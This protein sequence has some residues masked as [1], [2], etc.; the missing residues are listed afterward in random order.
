MPRALAVI[1][2]VSALSLLVG[3]VVALRGGGSTWSR[4]ADSY[5]RSAIGH[6][7]LANL[8]DELGIPV[9]RA[10]T[11]PREL[12]PR[13][14]VAVLCEPRPDADPDSIRALGRWE[15]YSSLAYRLLLVL[16]RWEAGA[17]H[18]EKV[19]WIGGRAELPTSTVDAVAGMLELPGRVVRPS[20]PLT[21]WDLPEDLPLPTLA[22]P[23]LL[24]A[25]DAGNGRL[26]P[27]WS[28]DQG[29]LLARWE[30]Q[31]TE[32]TVLVLSDPDL[33]NNLG[34]GR[35]ANAQ[36]A[37]AALALAGAPP[38]PVLIDETLHGH[39]LPRSPGAALLRP[40]LLWLLLHLG[41]L[42]LALLWWANQ[43]FG[44]PAPAT[45]AGRD[46]KAF[47]VASTASLLLVGGHRGHLLRRYLDHSIRGA[48]RARH[49]PATGPLRGVARRVD[50]LPG[51][52]RGPSAGAITLCD[53]MLARADRPLAAGGLLAAAR[54]IHA[55]TREM[56]HGTR[57]PARDHRP[58][59]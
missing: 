47:L 24:Q 49:V 53:R 19:H 39:A 18:P 36:L 17:V 5:S 50:R 35:G 32:E 16:P 58:A 27:V 9:Q 28:C 34:L 43:R 51:A 54:E 8:L 13:D 20:A 15:A 21:G 37:L 4:G 48:A 55:W 45:R 14:R 31:Y 57:R 10:R 22:D 1:V 56:H 30:R 6:R 33:F 7:G 52:R 44:D 41:L 11:V 2:A 29:L 12:L 25:T 3:L 26:E 59:A 42:A 38:G 40:P 46:G 23:Q